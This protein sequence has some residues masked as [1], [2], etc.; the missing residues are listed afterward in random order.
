MASAR[1]FIL[2]SSEPLPVTYSFQSWVENNTDSI[3][4]NLVLSITEFF[5]L[6][7]IWP[8]TPA[9]GIVDIDYGTLNL[10]SRPAQTATV[11]TGMPAG[12]RVTVYGQWQG[13]YVVHY[14]NYVGYAAAA[15]ISLR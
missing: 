7:F 2:Y 10:R 12:A 6:P 8:M 5:G 11:L 14:E 3:A 15:Y 13:W 4:Q 1:R 9:A